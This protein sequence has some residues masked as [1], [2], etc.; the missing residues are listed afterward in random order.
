MPDGT[1]KV[2]KK[3]IY[4][5]AFCCYGLSEYA[6]AV[7]ELKKDEELG[8]LTKDEPQFEDFDNQAPLY[9]KTTN[10]MLEDL[11]AKRTENEE[12]KVK[13]EADKKEVEAAEELIK[14]LKNSTFKS[15]VSCCLPYFRSSIPYGIM[16]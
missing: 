5:Q 11:T 8:L 15:Q 3:Q 14:D 2:D 1:P 9:L 4:G 13:V 10:E 6:A 7:Q 16:G 12:S